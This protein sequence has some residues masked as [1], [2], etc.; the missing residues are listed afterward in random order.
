MDMEKEFD[1]MQDDTEKERENKLADYEGDETEPADCDTLKQERGNFPEGAVGTEEKEKDRESGFHDFDEF[2]DKINS[3]GSSKNIFIQYRIENN[4]GVVAGRDVDMGDM[5]AEGIV[6]RPDGDGYHHAVVRDSERLGKWMAEHFGSFDMAFLIASAVF[7]NMPYIWINQAAEKLY[8]EQAD[9]MKKQ[10]RAREQRLKEFGAGLYQGNINTY[11]GKTTVD[12]ICFKEKEYA[13]IVLKYVWIEFPKLRNDLI[14]WLQYFILKGKIQM[15]KRATEVIG[16]FSG[17]DYYFF[18][19][20]LVNQI[21]KANSINNDMLLAR[22][23][24]QLKEQKEFE[25]QINKIVNYWSKSQNTHYL[26][27]TV[28]IC[29]EW[30][31][32]KEEL[33]TVV[34]SYLEDAFRCCKRGEEKE[35]IFEFFAS[36]MRGFTFYR[37]LIEKLYAMYQGLENRWEKEAFNILFVSLVIVDN[38]MLDVEN[39]EEAI[40]VKLSYTKSSVREMLSVLW[41]MVFQSNSY[42][43]QL[44]YILGQHYFLFS[45]EKADDMLKK[46]LNGVF[47]VKKSDAYKKEV[48]FQIKRWYRRCQHE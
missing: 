3:S 16:F 5:Y 30:K 29:A 7:E 27:T 14:C 10:E 48:L 43:K 31:E 33:K 42:R 4:H 38:G 11:A 44:Y 17:L 18:A 15:S 19:N 8:I 13:Q 47:G 36:G 28:L 23:V 21:I 6:K 9:N 20:E 41:Q 26:I 40:L 32:K 39:D 25:E 1:K 46:F 37:I 35:E 12:F 45:Q 24:I 34:H 2:F 22:I